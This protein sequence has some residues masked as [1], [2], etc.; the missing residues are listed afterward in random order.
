MLDLVQARASSPSASR[1]SSRAASGSASRWRAR[2]SSSPKLL[3]LD[4]PLGALDKK[5]REHTQFE[6]VNIQETA[7]RHLRRRDARPGRGDD[8]VDAHRRD[9][10]RRD[11][12]GRHAERDLR[13]PEFSAFVAEFIGSVNMFEGRLIE[14]EP[15]YVRIECDELDGADLRRSRRE[16]GARARRS[17]PR[18]GR[19]RSRSAARSRQRRTTGRTGIVRDIAYMGDMSVYLRAA[20]L[21]QGRARHAAERLPARRRSHHLGRAGLPA[22]ACLE[23]G[24]GDE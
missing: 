15:D 8:A 16:L 17:G 9:E 2:W 13:V 23:P 5:L 21:R 20:R 6:L 22:L 18:S 19:R 3:L 7:R 24:R 14:D 1:T 11:R 4:E 10:S 12:P